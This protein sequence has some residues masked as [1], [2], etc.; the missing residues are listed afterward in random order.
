MLG[1][2]VDKDLVGGGAAGMVSSWDGEQL[3]W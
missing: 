3:G 2:K 1:N